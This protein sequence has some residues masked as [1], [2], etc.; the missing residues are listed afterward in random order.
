[1]SVLEKVHEIVKSPHQFARNWKEETGGKVLGYLCTNIPEELL[2]AAGVLPVR[3]LGT[4]E[5]EA[6]TKPYIFGAAFCSFARD[7][8]AQALHG[9]YDYIDGITMGTCC[10]HA[11]HVFDSW[12]KHIPVSYSYELSTPNYLLNPHAK[13]FLIRELEDHKHSLEEWTGKEI[14]LEDLDKAIEVYNTNRRLMQSIYELMKADDP[15]VAV[16]EVAEIALAGMLID[17]ETHNIFLEE[18]LEELPK[19]KSTGNRGPRLMLI[20]SVNNNMEFIKFIDS[21]GGRVVIDDYCTGNRYYQVEVIP[22]ENRLAALAGRIIGKPPCPLKD[23]PV[24][25]RS[26]HHSKLA[27]DYRVQGAINTIHRVC[28]PHGLDYPVIE[29]SF[30]EKDIPMLKL[31]LDYSFPVEQFR[32][33]IEAFLEM[34]E[35]S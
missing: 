21:L 5:P 7:C 26:V 14:S 24:R 11:L 10:P 23:L 34:I 16:A 18:A 32:T 28:D 13:K 1:M 4:N 20:G 12:K 25:R 17:K 8:F 3:L 2:Y 31:E 6:I 29:S 22:E 15:P 35:A 27:D 33:R 30:K 9:R 19:R